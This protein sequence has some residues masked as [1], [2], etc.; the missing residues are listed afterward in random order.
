MAD[1]RGV[2]YMG[3]RQVEVHDIDF[4]SFELKDGPG[5]NPAN[6]GRK[7]PH[8][9]ILKIVSTNICGSD[10]HMVRGRTTAPEGLILGHEITGEVIETGR[11]VEFIKKGD[12]VSVPF[13]IACG[14]CRNC[15]EQATGICLNTN[16]ERPGSAYGYVDMGGWVGGQAEYVMVP[17][18]DWN[19]LKFPDKDQALE[20][21]LDLTMLS[22]IFP[23]G[24]HGCVTA[25]VKSGSTVY[26]AGAGPVG[27][28]AAH[29]AQFLGAAV[30]I[31]GD[32]NAD[33]LRQAESFGCA[34]V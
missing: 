29:S 4:P 6:V 34:T 20:K 22:D 12:L 15:K 18:A 8:G 25:G 16:P 11:D 32:L 30:V 17:Y 2:A 24:Y 21:I 26:I 5:V 28:A 31:V 27:L 7:L 3:P 13:N 10:Q 23:T 19:L 9:V 14:R 33:R 1:N